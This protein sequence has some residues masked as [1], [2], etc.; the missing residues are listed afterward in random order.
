MIYNWTDY[1]TSGKFKDWDVYIMPK[2]TPLYQGININP[3]RR[4]I[5]DYDE[6]LMNN[7]YGTLPIAS[8][9]AFSDE[10]TK[11]EMG[12]IVGY[13]TT[14][15]LY[16]LNMESIHNY[17]RIYQ[18]SNNIPS[19]VASDEDIIQYAF[20]YKT[21]S[22]KL[23]RD[24]HYTID[25]EFV[26]W[27]CD[28]KFDGIDGYTYLNLPGFHNEVFMCYQN[29][30]PTGYEYRF[31]QYFD[32]ESIYETYN[33]L[34]TGKKIPQSELKYIAN[35]KMNNVILKYNP[36][37]IYRPKT[38]KDLFL[39]QEPFLSLRNQHIQKINYE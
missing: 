15:K 27:F 4:R 39:L 28:Q 21:G 38:N 16:L 9:Y 2:G 37:V 26:N 3:K 12:K 24:S 6:R 35:N 22:D 31:I 29:V 33:G 34:L 17:E 32:P 8:Y 25:K 5:H 23:Y 11:G 36:Y 14:R 18:I 10:R 19:G 1:V 7:F 20:G 30:E 13:R